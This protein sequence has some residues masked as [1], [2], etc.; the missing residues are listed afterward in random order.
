MIYTVEILTTAESAATLQPRLQLGYSS[1]S[2]AQL[3]VPDEVSARQYNRSGDITPSLLV[4][5]PDI[6]IES[7]VLD[8]TVPS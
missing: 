7:L 8:D 3:A 2:Q 1:E 6:E 5:T 4:G